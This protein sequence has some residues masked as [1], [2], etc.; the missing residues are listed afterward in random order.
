SIFFKN[1]NVRDDLNP[2]AE[3]AR[4]LASI[5]INGCSVN[6]VNAD[7]HIL[8]SKFIPQLAR[9]AAA[10]R[11]YGVQL[12]VSVN[13]SAPKSLGGLATFDP[14]DPQ[15][16]DWWN[17]KFEEVYRAIPDFGGV[18]VKADSEGQSGPSTYER[19]AADAAN[20]LA[21]AL[22]PHGGL[23]FYRAF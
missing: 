20:V 7:A 18:V 15:V 3:Y 23:V 2:A 22:K 8:D 11:P 5:G 17:K 12:G 4:L 13:V 10:F 6:N 1:G 14:K 16:A 9:I 21:R 19:N